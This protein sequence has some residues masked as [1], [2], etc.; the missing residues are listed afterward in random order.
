[1]FSTRRALC[2]RALSSWKTKEFQ[3]PASV[4]PPMPI[5]PLYHPTSSSCIV[6][7]TDECG[8]YFECPLSLSSIQEHIGCHILD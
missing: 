1:M 4:R 2:G 8:G 6:T 5:P 3:C 7:F